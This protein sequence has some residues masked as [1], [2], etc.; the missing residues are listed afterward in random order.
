MQRVVIDDPQ[1]P[2]T[3]TGETRCSRLALLHL[4]LR[5][6]VNPGTLSPATMRRLIEEGVDGE[7]VSPAQFRQMITLGGDRSEGDALSADEIKQQHLRSFAFASLVK[8]W[9]ALAFEYQVS[10]IERWQSGDE[11][12]GDSDLFRLLLYSTGDAALR[13]TREAIAQLA[14]RR[15]Y[16]RATTQ[17]ESEDVLQRVVEA[18]RDAVARGVRAPRAAVAERLA[19]HPGHV[20]RLLSIARERGML[21]PTK[22]R[23][24]RK[25]S[26]EREAPPQ[27]KEDL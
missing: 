10:C 8:Q 22:P 20:G 18:Y 2:F 15:P 1:L 21:P 5:T 23:G 27:P 25:K 6:P 17:E 26:E 7:T 13:A 16:R 3:V 4:E 9:A 14:Q 11:N 12:A 24:R 19:Y